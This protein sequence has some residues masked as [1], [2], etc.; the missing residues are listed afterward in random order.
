MWLTV[1]PG[2]IWHELEA[3]IWHSTC[4]SY[5][6]SPRSNWHPPWCGY[7]RASIVEWPAGR[8][9]WITS[10][11]WDRIW[12][13]V[14]AL[15]VILSLKLLLA[16]LRYLRVTIFYKNFGKLKK[17]QWENPLYLLRSDQ[18]FTTSKPLSFTGWKIHHASPTEAWQKNLRWIP[19]SSG[20]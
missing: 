8:T 20:A 19:L 5:V 1:T 11:I 9:T 4:R 13:L 18:S 17:V 14:T 12:L 15:L 10:C 2:A 6:W 3:S 16:M 7:L